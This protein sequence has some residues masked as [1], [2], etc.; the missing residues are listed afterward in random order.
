[1]ARSESLL[2][3]F[4][5]TSFIISIKGYTGSIDCYSMIILSPTLRLLCSYGCICISNVLPSACA[6]SS[7]L[8]PVNSYARSAVSLSAVAAALGLG[9]AIYLQLRYGWITPQEFAVSPPGLPSNFDLMQLATSASRTFFIYFNLGVAH[10]ILI[11]C[12][13][14]CLTA[15]S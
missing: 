11:Y 8:F 10:F 14:F 13:F 4:S 5:T 7:S 3:S 2:F 9:C 12:P 1:M 6:L 15:H